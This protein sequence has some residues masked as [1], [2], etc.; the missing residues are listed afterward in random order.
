VYRY[1]GEC[2]EKGMKKKGARETKGERKALTNFNQTS[3]FF[4]PP[5]NI[6][7]PPTKLYRCTVIFIRVPEGE[8]QGE[9]GC[10]L[11]DAIG[12]PFNIP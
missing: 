8:L 3:N 1:Y 4:F 11:Q 6:S 12:F 5:N 9:G 10:S 7:S 2:R